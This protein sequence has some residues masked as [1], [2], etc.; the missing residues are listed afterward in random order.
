MKRY[1]CNKTQYILHIYILLISSPFFPVNSITICSR[2]LL[3]NTYIY[4]FT[5]Y[6]M[7]IYF[8]MR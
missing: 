8:L 6:Y 3:Q 1:V 5:K 2:F 4:I 7:I